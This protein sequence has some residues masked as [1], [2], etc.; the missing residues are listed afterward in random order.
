[1]PEYLDP[2]PGQTSPY[3]YASSYGGRGYNV[4]GSFVHV[5]LNLGSP[6]VA[7]TNPTY[8]Y[9]QSAATTEGSAAAVPYNKNSFQIISPG[10]DTQ[11]GIGGAYDKDDGFSGFADEVQ[12]DNIT[13]FSGGVLDPS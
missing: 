6:S 5:D 4:N 11:Y 2:L 1:M 13:N 10:L 9:L 12:K 7:S 8:V 3:L